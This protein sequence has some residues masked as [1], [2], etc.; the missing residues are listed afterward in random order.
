MSNFSYFNCY[1]K[2]Q[3]CHILV[4]FGV[5]L[6]KLDFNIST[7]VS[8]FLKP[9]FINEQVASG[10]RDCSSTPP[11]VCLAAL[12]S[13]CKL[14]H[15]YFTHDTDSLKLALYHTLPPVVRFCL[16]ASWISHAGQ[17]S[18]KRTAFFPVNMLNAQNCQKVA[19]IDAS[20]V[21]MCSNIFCPKQW[22]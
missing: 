20:L 18:L 14:S 21:T 2:G 4:V 22:F 7:L 13:K 15:K 19:K 5:F 12:E 1:F 9:H 17:Q 6:P 10:G 3:I 11:G 16:A 8:C